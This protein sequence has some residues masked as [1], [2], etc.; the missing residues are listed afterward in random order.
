M[1][2]RKSK[3][4]I[5][6]TV[7]LYSAEGKKKGTIDLDA[8]VFGQPVSEGLLYS[9]VL[10]YQ[11]NQRVG[12]ASTKVRNQVRGGGKKPWRQ[13]GTGRARVGSIRNPLWRGGGTVFGPHPRSFKYQLSQK[14]K[15]RALIDSLTT[16]LQEGAFRVMSDV[17]MDEPKTKKFKAII[18]GMKID[19][20][21][22]IAMDKRPHA[23]ILASRN[24]QGV[25]V[26]DASQISA[27]DVLSSEHFVVTEKALKILTERLKV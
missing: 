8:K 21:V 16:R 26:A 24:L 3:K 11:S 4:E 7:T 20:S 2:A 14:M 1:T 18:D 27:M 17:T 6:R 19:G 22:L 10:M 23:V 13:K 15:R 9:A 12:L 5:S 25:T